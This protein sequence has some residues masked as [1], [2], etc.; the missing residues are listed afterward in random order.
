MLWVLK[1][2]VSKIENIHNFAPTFFCF[3]F[4]CR[5]KQTMNFATVDIE[6]NKKLVGRFKIETHLKGIL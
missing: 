3:V 6:V 5:K 1:R 2:T 4:F